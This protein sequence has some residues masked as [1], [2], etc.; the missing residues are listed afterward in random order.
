MKKLSNIYFLLL[1]FAIP[2]FASD[3]KG[4]NYLNEK[5]IK[6]ETKILLE[7]S[8]GNVTVKLYDGTPKHRDN[9]IKLV[10]DGFY[11]GVLFHR[12]IAGFMVQTGDPDSKNAAPNQHLGAGNVG[13]TLPAEFVYP[14]Y[15]HKK[16]ALAAA[17]TSDAVNPQKESSG[18]QFYIV[19]GKISSNAELDQMEASK[20]NGFGQAIFQRKVNE[21]R[22]LIQQLQAAN[23]EQGLR[24]LQTRLIQE[25]EAEL[26]S[27][28]PFKFTSEQRQDYTTIGGTPFLDN[29]YTVFGEV[30]E[31]LNIVDSI[32]V[33]KTASGDRPV[34]DVKILKAS[35][36]Q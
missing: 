4:K 2:L 32:S 27:A 19:T 22:E 12:I 31:G 21:N 34:E 13:Y 10:N 8:L 25:V 36:I 35:I 33:V 14:Q 11:E 17:R 20:S 30:V 6:M 16:G 18:S 3:T 5:E 9:F 28:A 24:D 7:T 23:D 1:L 26:T 15:Y 29:E